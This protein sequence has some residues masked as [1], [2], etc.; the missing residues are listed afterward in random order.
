MYRNEMYEVK[1]TEK[2]MRVD[3]V[4]IRNRSKRIPEER[5]WIKS[6]ELQYETY[7]LDLFIGDN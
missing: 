4:W 2:R 1:S 6:D 3:Q 7:D 5:D